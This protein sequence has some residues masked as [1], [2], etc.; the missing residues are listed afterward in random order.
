MK[1][2]YARAGQQN[3]SGMKCTHQP[4]KDD[5]RLNCDVEDRRVK[6]VKNLEFVGTDRGF[7][8]PSVRYTHILNHETKNL[9]QNQRETYHV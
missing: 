2:Y 3:P 8:P 7:I 6:E 4:M 1:K 5:V 9:T